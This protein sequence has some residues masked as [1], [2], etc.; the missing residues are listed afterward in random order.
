MAGTKTSRR[1]AIT[2]AVDVGGSGLKASVLD[3]RGAMMAK[4]VR[5]DTPHPCTP[6]RLVDAIAHLVAPLPAWHRISVGFPGLIRHG[7]V[8]TAPNLDSKAFAGFDL[9]GALTKRLGAP[10]RAVN[11]A[12]MQGLAVIKGRGVELVCTLG[13]GFG[14][15]LFHDGVLQL[16]L[17]LG[18]FPFHKGKTFDQALGDKNRKNI[19]NKRWARLLERALLPLRAV[20]GFDRLYLGGG[21]ARRIDFKLPRDVVVVDNDA[22]I[23]GGVRLWDDKLELAV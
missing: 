10:C 9:A 3:E 11:D 20:V 19:G 14:T 2:L 23:L 13:T 7:Q 17:D 18:H 21:N 16:H 4:R 6:K 15:A 22:G 12:D 5:I 1:A 8:R